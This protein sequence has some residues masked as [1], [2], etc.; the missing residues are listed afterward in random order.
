[1]KVTECAGA[2]Y[3]IIGAVVARVKSGAGATYSA[4]QEDYIM[5]DKKAPTYAY[6]IA[7]SKNKTDMV[8]NAPVSLGHVVPCPS[9]V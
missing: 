8:C 7:N 9:E 5:N 3:S 6:V 1:M 2:A 4:R